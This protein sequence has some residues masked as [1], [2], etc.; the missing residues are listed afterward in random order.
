M[1]D[2]IPAITATVSFTESA[3][4]EMASTQPGNNDSLEVSQ[5]EVSHEHIDSSQP[6]LPESS[7]AFKLHDGEDIT[8]LPSS[9]HE[10]SAHCDFTDFPGH[11]VRFLLDVCCGVKAPLSSSVQALGGDILAFDILRCHQD[12]ILDT[13]RFTQL[14]RLC[15]SGVVA[16]TACSPSCCEFSRLKLRPGGPRALR[17]PEFPDGRPDLTGE[18]LLRVQESQLML[19]RCILL[20]QT[21]IA[22]GGHGHLE[23]PSSAMSW[24]QP[25]VQDFIRQHSITCCHVAACG[26]GRNWYKSWLFASTLPTLATLACVCNHPVGSHEQ[27]GGVRTVSGSFKSRETAE[28]PDELCVKM[29]HLLLPLLTKNHSNFSVEQALEVLPIKSRT[30][31]PFVRHDGGGFPSAGDWSAVHGQPDTFSSIRKRFMQLILDQRLDKQIIA[32]FCQGRDEPPFSSDQLEPFRLLL[33]EFLLAQGFTPDWSVPDNQPLC[34]AILDGLSSCMEDPDRI[35]FQYLPQGVP[36][37]VDHDI[38]PSQCFPPN[39]NPE[40]NESMLSV[41]HTNWMSAEENP[42]TVLELIRK[43]VTEG[44]VRE[45]HGTLEEAQSFFTHGIAV[46]KLG[47]ALSESRPPRLVLDSSVCGV[48]AQCTIPEHS[49]LPT[50]RD[51]LRAFPLRESRHELAGVSFDVRSAHKRIA[52]HPKFHGYLC[53]QFQGRIFYYTVCPFGAVFSAHF[54][55]RLGSFYLRLFH[56]FCYLPHSAFLYV[57][58]MVMFQDRQILPIST[59]LV[60]ILCMLTQLPISWKKC[61][62]GSDLTWIG[63][64]I[65][66]DCGIIIL[67]E[68]KRIKILKLLD[69]LL[70]SSHCS[71]KHLEQFLGLALW[72]TQLWPHMR[73]W[74]HFMYRDL[75]SIPASQFSVAPDDWELL[76]SCLSDDLHFIRRPP[77]TAIPLQGHLIQVRHQ[78]V[79]N[80]TDLANCRLSDKRIWLRIRDPNSKKRKLSVDSRRVSRMFHNWLGTISPLVSMWPKPQFNGTCVADAFASGNQAGIGGAIILPSGTMIWYSLRLHLSQFQALQIPMHDDLQKDISCLETLAQ[81]ALLYIMVHRIPGHR[82]SLRIPTLSD[83]TSAESASNKL[84]STRMPLALFLERMSILLSSSSLDVDVQH[85]PGHSNDLADTLSRWDGSLPI[86][87]N[88]QPEQRFDLCLQD[89]WCLDRKAKL[90]PPDTRIPWSL[91]T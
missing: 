67:P 84:F 21:T 40:S 63:W 86:P 25:V 8:T 19:E 30:S 42:E 24:D 22:A 43:E 70:S 17:T 64:Q 29:A 10:V 9:T 52:V 20:L 14:L 57:D 68:T 53:F 28:Y 18:E 90:V 34:I 73:T 11:S 89:L 82:V 71:R 75:Y 65:H 50:I 80:K 77:N 41:H 4:G 51:V 72:V 12:D 91:P 6:P 62:F 13:C 31:P 49:T 7:E 59:A 60:G 23:Q 35:L 27:I 48:N 3:N 32:A 47:L 58:D 5:P 45:F 66:I 88:C 26:Y 16:Y 69:H 55:S 76:C 85:I 78:T 46:G 39:E 15:A 87:C 56:R 61:E 74:M 37:G 54:W 1:D 33:N 36:I 38:V 2:G 44:W 79:Q 83:N 81:H